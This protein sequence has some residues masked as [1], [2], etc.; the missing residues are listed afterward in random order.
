M[1][2]E[3]WRG[4]GATRT[5]NFLIVR[6][7][8]VARDNNFERWIRSRMK[9]RERFERTDFFREPRTTRS[10]FYLDTDHPYARARKKEK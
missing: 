1:N 7:I 2:G 4:R 10:K 5:T 6:M 8:I 3:G 9:N